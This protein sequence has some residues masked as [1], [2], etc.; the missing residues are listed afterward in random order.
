MNLSCIT[1]VYYSCTD[2]PLSLWRAKELSCVL[3]KTYSTRIASVEFSKAIFYFWDAVQQ[4][5]ENPGCNI[6][7]MHWQVP[8]IKHETCGCNFLHHSWARVWVS[9]V[10]TVVMLVS[11]FVYSDYRHRR[12][13]LWAGF[14]NWLS[15]SKPGVPSSHSRNNLLNQFPLTALSH[16]DRQKSKSSF[17]L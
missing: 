7:L 17:D 8:G 5:H 6:L 15:L 11:I 13:P 2:H 1:P 12:V 10:K 9:V 14:H 3:R 4:Q 16:N